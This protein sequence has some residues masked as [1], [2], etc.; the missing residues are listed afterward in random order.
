MPFVAEHRILSTSNFGF[1]KFVFGCLNNKCNRRLLFAYYPLFLLKIR[2]QIVMGNTYFSCLDLSWAQAQPWPTR[3]EVETWDRTP[4]H[5]YL[6]CSMQGNSLHRFKCN[7]K[8]IHFYQWSKRILPI[9]GFSF[10]WAN[11][12]KYQRANNK[13]LLYISTSVWVLH[14]PNT[15]RNAHFQRFCCRYFIKLLMIHNFS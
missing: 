14:T 5:Q 9:I 1:F 2:W 3:L 10:G 13:Y 12:S 6:Y 7:S 8:F 4:I 11:H 15:G